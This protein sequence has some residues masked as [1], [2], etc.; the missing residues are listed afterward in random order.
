[1]N[2]AMKANWLRQPAAISLTPDMPTDRKPSGALADLQLQLGH[3][4]QLMRLDRPVGIWLLL[5]PTL[6]G[7]W[8]AAEGRPDAWVFAVFVAGAVVMRSAGCVINDFADRKL[9][10]LVT[11]TRNRPLITGTVAPAEALVLFAALGMIAVGLVLSLD[12]LTQL[13]AIGAAALTLIYPFCKRFISAPQLVL[14]AAF[15]WGIPMAFA[16]QTGQLPRLAWLLALA[17]VIWAVAYD[18]MYAMADRDDDRRAGIRSTAILFGDAD[19]F[20]VSLLQCLFLMAMLLAG[21]VAQLGVWYQLGLLAAAA[22]MVYQHTLIRRRQAADCLRAFLHN[23]H[24]GAVIFA[25]IMLDYSLM[26]GS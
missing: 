10:G 19:V 6:W 18:T 22:C 13:L 9:D 11:R 3:Y 2:L 7:L 4:A 26:A 5:W 23:R 24:V 17:V 25:G 16:A 21:A 12:R 20:I 1:M 8:I 15:A 14:G